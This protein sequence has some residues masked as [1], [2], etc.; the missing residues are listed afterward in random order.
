MTVATIAGTKRPAPHATPRA[1]VNHRALA[2]VKPVIRF[3]LPDRCK[4]TP[5]PT[6]PIPV[7]MPCT[8]C[9]TGAPL[10]R[11]ALP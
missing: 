1:A 9:G 6:K 10:T 5:A 2:V 8:V 11:P 3:L 7:T 4:I